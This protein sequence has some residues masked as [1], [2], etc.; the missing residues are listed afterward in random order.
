M[1][2]ALE[3]GLGLAHY[4]SLVLRVID[5]DSDGRA[6]GLRLSPLDRII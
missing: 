2:S 4:R 6:P 3:S 1:H 5:S